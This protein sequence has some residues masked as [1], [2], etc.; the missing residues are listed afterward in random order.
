MK[1]IVFSFVLFFINVLLFIQPSSAGLFSKTPT[2]EYF[3]IYIVDNGDLIELK[4][5]KLS[6]AGNL[7]NAIVGLK[8]P[9]KI[10]INDEEAYIILYS[11]EIPYS[12]IRLSKLE[13]QSTGQVQ[14]IMSKSTV[15]VNMWVEKENVKL[16]IAPI[17]DK[18]DMYRL[19]PDMPLV[20]GFYAVHYGNLSTGSTLEA[21]GGG[22]SV[23]DF[24]VGSSE[25]FIKIY[26]ETVKYNTVAIPPF[27]TTHVID[28][29]KIIEPDSKV[30]LKKVLYELERKSTVQM[31]VLT[32]TS[33]KD[34][35]IESFSKRTIE[36][37]K[38]GRKVENSYI[39]LT[40][41]LNDRKYRFEVG[42]ELKDIL[43]DELVGSIG[44]AEL[45]QPFKKG[46][47]S[48]GIYSATIAIVDK[49]YSYKKENSKNLPKV[50][51]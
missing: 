37:W 45:V 30:E 26:E 32:L 10:S 18:D 7:M 38:L 12:S 8:E 29:A 31:V 14:N 36:K 34:N 23:F 48:Q 20:D 21:V 43:T 19:I 25:Q 47:Y 2:P 41:S 46:D 35:S 9:A 28:L 33:L 39:L 11:K 49:I 40:I 22:K 44:R 6:W 42:D 4:E 15:D 3:G 24:V 13:F 27:P 1:K 16:R 51:F 50:K 17:K 5:H